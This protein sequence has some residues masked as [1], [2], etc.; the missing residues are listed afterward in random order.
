[1]PAFRRPALTALLAATAVVGAGT[2]VAQAQEQEQPLG[3]GPTVTMTISNNT[4][5]AMLLAGAEAAA[6]VFAAAPPTTI[7][8]GAVVVVTAEGHEQ[9]GL[10]A[11]VTYTLPDGT[12]ATYAANDFEYT[13]NTDGTGFTGAN[14]RL[15]TTTRA[16]DTASPDLVVTYVTTAA[17]P[18]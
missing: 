5:Q 10:S 18:L 11:T 6:G 16:L 14:A 12:A 1:M 17:A 7:E 15:Y 13:A 2:G 4:G 8:P 3:D 9:V